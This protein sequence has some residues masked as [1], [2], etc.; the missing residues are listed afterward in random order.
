MA[1]QEPQKTSPFLE[2]LNKKARSLEVSFYENYGVTELDD[3]LSQKVQPD[4]RHYLYHYTNQQGAYG[5]L[6]SK[7]IWASDPI[8]LNDEQEIRLGMSAF[9]EAF[10]EVKA[11]KC[12]D[13]EEIKNIHDYLTNISDENNREFKGLVRQRAYTVSLTTESD[14]LSQWRGYGGPAGVALGFQLSLLE[15]ARPKPFFAPILYGTE[16][17]FTELLYKD[18]LYM[19][20]NLKHNGSDVFSRNN[21][22]V[23]RY[24]TFLPL[25]K[26]KAFEAENEWRMVVTGNRMTQS[27]TE[28]RSTFNYAIPYIKI[29]LWKG[30]EQTSLSWDKHIVPSQPDKEPHQGCWARLGP[31]ASPLAEHYFDSKLRLVDRSSVPFRTQ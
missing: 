5:I 7:S 23:T 26:H 19:L 31:G 11:S 25:I 22:L 10:K 14:D 12:E 2:C 27:E 21:A 20:E 17:M 29:A 3:V 24:L 15:G 4:S 9:D 16:E 28:W 8:F 18:I 1:E 30:G 13:Y 6:E